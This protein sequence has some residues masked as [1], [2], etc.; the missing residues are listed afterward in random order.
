MNKIAIIELD[1][2]F[3][4]LLNTCKIFNELKYNTTIIT[5]EKFFNELNRLDKFERINWIIWKDS[6]KLTNFLRNNIKKINE[7]D[8]LIF[9]T[10]SRYFKEFSDLRLLPKT[11]V[12]VHNANAYFAPKQNIKLASDF[13]YL[14]KDLNYFLINVIYRKEWKYR[15]QFIRKVNNYTFPT[16]IIKNYI[17][18]RSLLSLDKIVEPIPWS[19]ISQDYDKKKETKSV[20]IT[21]TGSIDR[22][23]RDYTLLYQVLA[24]TRNQYSR[25]VIL[26]FLGKPKNNYE[27]LTIKKFKKLE[28][29]KLK[30]VS[31]LKWVPQ[32]EFDEIMK[33]T[34]FLVIPLEKEVKFTIYRELNG[35]TKISGNVN[36]IILYRK[37]AIISS[38]YP[39]DA[40]L[41]TV[42]KGY[43]NKEDFSRILLQ[44]INQKEFQ[45][46]N[47][48]FDNICSEFSFETT[49]IKVERVIDSILN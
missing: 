26:T 13:F 4:V 7:Y 38:T 20:Y 1:H 2:H 34:D 29:D 44:W 12:R 11:I 30:F 10:F 17:L 35:Y 40:S 23:R 39:L 9:N 43:K 46:Y 28:T 27:K 19:F 37:P 6:E 24:A 8:L 45:K 32:N 48:L 49:K 22:R 18:S 47:Q 31:F 41:K 21:L 5:K 15:S 14:L 16:E 3:E 25:K 42:T 33:K 36:D